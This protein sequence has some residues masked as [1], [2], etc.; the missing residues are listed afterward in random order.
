MPVCDEAM[1]RIVRRNPD[2]HPVTNDHFDI[3]SFHF[4]AKAGFDLNAVMKIDGINPTT[5]HV[6]DLAFYI[7][8]II[9][10]HIESFLGQKKKPTPK[11]RLY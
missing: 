3:E 4:P 8:Q 10:G 6:D 9:F 2:G 5:R 7:Y 1:S 11:D